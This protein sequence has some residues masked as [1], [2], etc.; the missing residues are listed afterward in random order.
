M[1]EEAE[2]GVI[3]LAEALSL[4]LAQLRQVSYGRRKGGFAVFLWVRSFFMGSH[5]YVF[6][7]CRFVAGLCMAF[8]YLQC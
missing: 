6:E 4:T 8:A 7:V 3:A 1:Q 5:F 2:L